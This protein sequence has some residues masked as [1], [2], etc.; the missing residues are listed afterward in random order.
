MTEFWSSEPQDEFEAKLAEE[1]TELRRTLHRQPRLSGD[2]ADTA[3]L[4]AERL[5]PTRPT[6][7]LRGVGGHGLLAIYEGEGGAG[8]T[9]LLRTEI[10]ALPLNDPPD[11]PHRSLRPGVA[12]KCGHDGHAA[13]LFAVARLLSRRALT[14]G[15]VALLFQ[16]SEETGCGMRSVLQCPKFQPWIPD[17]AFAW[18]N[19]PGEPLGTV[20]WRPDTF[21]AASIGIIFTYRGSESH[22][23][24]P[25]LGRNPAAAGAAL[26][27]SALALP[28]AL[29]GLESGHLVTPTGLCMGDGSFG[30]SP[31]CLEL[32][33]TARASTTDS[34]QKLVR[35][36]QSSA[37]HLAAQWSLEL[38]IEY[39]EPFLA[40]INCERA[41]DLV[42]EAAS[43]LGFTTLRS[44]RTHA[45]SEDFGELLA[46]V[47]GAFF[48]IGAGLE[49]PPLHSADYDFPDRL[50]IP[51]ARLMLALAQ[52]ASGLHPEPKS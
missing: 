38:S 13:S 52:R 30:T 50:I 45:W 29:G 32:R 39:C 15:R 1:C 2:E 14:Q 35:R 17:W 36:L 41:A 16:P 40:T 27:Q 51:G 23:S 26:I 5:S 46:R 8:S 18:H 43:G 28:A 31:E 12:H 10:D 22:A 49:H 48:T 6:R 24:Q 21:C 34:L 20:G 19:L 44:P 11:L 42:Q 33:F 25:Q 37:E 7:L 3:N 9:V 47:P 4:L